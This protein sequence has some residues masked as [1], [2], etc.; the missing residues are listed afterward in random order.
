[1]KKKVLAFLFT[2]IMCFG[3]L[4]G[5]FSAN[6]GIVGEHLTKTEASASSFNVGGEVKEYWG[7]N[8]GSSKYSVY[9][10]AKY[11]KA[12]IWYEDSSELMKPGYKTPQGTAFITRKRDDSTTWFVRL[13]PK[14]AL[15]KDCE[16]WGYMNV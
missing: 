14:G 12:F 8:S 6:S 7:S 9:L 15:N 3:V 10:I 5:A 2:M 16:A 13:N 4:D 1:M 11:K